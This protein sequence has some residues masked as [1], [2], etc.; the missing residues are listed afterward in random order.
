MFNTPEITLELVDDQEEANPTG[1]GVMRYDPDETQ[2]V[3]PLTGNVYREARQST[4]LQRR[5]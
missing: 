3:D 5:L 2:L 4:K 1:T